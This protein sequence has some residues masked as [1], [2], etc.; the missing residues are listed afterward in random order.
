MPRSLDVG[1]G[2]AVLIFNHFGQL[3]IL[4]R[5]GAHWADYWSVPGGWVDRTDTSTALAVIR[6]ALEEA[7]L[8]VSS[9]D[10]YT[11][12]CE[13]NPEIDCRTVTLYHIAHAGTWTGEARI[14]EPNKCSEL[15]WVY[16]D[17]L[18]EKMF[19]GSREVILGV[20]DYTVF[21]NSAVRQILVAGSAH[22]PRERCPKVK[23]FYIH[24]TG[25]ESFVIYGM[26]EGHH[27]TWGGVN[28]YITEELEPN[29]FHVIRV[30]A[31][32]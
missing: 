28:K 5:A 8:I 24:D 11:W 6:E 29:G 32:P 12:S 23:I 18:P 14:M 19:P 3:L 30:V 26:G 22:D 17:E 21:R 25:D 1:V 2:T 7:G 20:P 10:N 4:K 16:R 13:D 9:V 15:R 31:F 27:Q